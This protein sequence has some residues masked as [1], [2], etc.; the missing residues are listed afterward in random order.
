MLPYQKEKNIL[1]NL[2]L[3][4]IHLGKNLHVIMTDEELGKINTKKDR[5]SSAL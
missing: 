2:L 1:K 3:E 5:L 4:I